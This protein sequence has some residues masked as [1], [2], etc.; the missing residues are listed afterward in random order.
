LLIHLLWEGLPRVGSS[1]LLDRAV[2]MITTATIPLI[3]VFYLFYNLAY[4]PMLITYT[5]E[6]LPYAIRAK[7]FALMVRYG[8]IVLVSIITHFSAE[9][10]RFILVGAQPGCR[11]LGSKCD[12]LEIRGF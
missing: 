5:L 10:G 12:R 3:F 11:S 7:G 2:L 6:I 4:T 8:P 9:F 1:K